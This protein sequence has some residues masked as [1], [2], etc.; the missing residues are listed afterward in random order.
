MAT[1]LDGLLAKAAPDYQRELSG[2]GAEEGRKAALLRKRQRKLQAQSADG[3]AASAVSG[4]GDSVRSDKY[5][6]PHNAALREAVEQADLGRTGLLD[7]FAALYAAIVSMNE[8]RSGEKGA[9]DSVPPAW[10]LEKENRERREKERLQQQEIKMLSDAL[11]DVRGVLL[12]REQTLGEVRRELA[13]VK[14]ENMEKEQA[15][16][17]QTVSAEESQRVALLGLGAELKAKYEQDLGRLQREHAQQ[18]AELEAQKHR[19]ALELRRELKAVPPLK[20]EPKTDGTDIELWKKILS[21]VEHMHEQLDEDKA[22][23]EGMILH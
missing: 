23:L 21:Q 22:A 9:L 4:T 2:G 13:R 10:E 3:D 12:E 18:L 6:S 15:L 1:V 11:S 20:V 14:Q 17:L 8:K 16:E 5:V 19:E 7:R